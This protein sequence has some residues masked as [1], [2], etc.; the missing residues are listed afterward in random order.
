MSERWLYLANLQIERQCC[1]WDLSTVS[2]YG[3]I[4]AAL[5][6][7]IELAQEMT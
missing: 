2:P 4:L 7:D 1:I 3:S 5:P 6:E